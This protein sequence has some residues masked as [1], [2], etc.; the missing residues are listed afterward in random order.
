MGK[1][2]YL[3]SANTE[4]NMKRGKIVVTGANGQLGSCLRDICN[5]YD[6]YDFI[7]TDIEELDITKDIAVA[8]FFDFHRPQWVI[9]AAAYTAVD[10]AEQNIELARLLNCSAVE[11]LATNSKRI[12]AGFVHISTDYVFDGINNEPITEEMPTNPQSIYGITKLEGEAKAK[13]NPNHIILRTSW[14][15]SIYGNNFVKTMRN[16]GTKNNEVRVVCDQWGC[17]T[18]A[19]DLAE[20]IMSA[21]TKADS[22][23]NIYGTY[24]FSNNGSTSWAEFAQKIMDFSNLNCH[25]IPITTD[26]YPTAAKRPA[27]SVMDKSKFSKTFSYVIADWQDSLKKVIS[28]F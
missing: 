24:H 26:M 6:L 20:A 12:G 16:I 25:V 2:N 1:Y 4:I 21:I 14:L 17:P 23:D 5:S 10:K 28:K 9:N 7:F 22:G 8:D 15:Y 18:S 13:I 27:F 19:E 3:C 11:I